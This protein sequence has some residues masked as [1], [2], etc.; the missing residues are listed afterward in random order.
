MRMQGLIKSEN[1]SFYSVREREVSTYFLL[2][3]IAIK[4]NNRTY[5]Y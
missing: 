5:F 3:T 4:I 2:A 1:F